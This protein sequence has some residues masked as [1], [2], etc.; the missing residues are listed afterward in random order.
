MLRSIASYRRVR[1]MPDAF[2]ET[3][4]LAA[5]TSMGVMVSV[6]RPKGSR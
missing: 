1:R 6:S 4:S 2:S 3:V 5:A